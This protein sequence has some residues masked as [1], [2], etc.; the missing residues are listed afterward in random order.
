MRSWMGG[1]GASAHCMSSLP[2]PASPLLLP[3]LRTSTTMS[4][5]GSS[6]TASASLVTST[7][8][9]TAKSRT[10]DTSRHKSCGRRASVKVGTAEP[11]P[12]RPQYRGSAKS[13]C[14][15]REPRSLT[16]CLDAKV[17]ALRSVQVSVALKQLYDATA[18]DARTTHRDVPRA[19]RPHSVCGPC[20]PRS[21]E[22]GRPRRWQSAFHL[23]NLV[24]HKQAS[25]LLE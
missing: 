2:I 18:N 13:C 19:K 4:M 23:I 8:S 17:D 24:S 1:A 10:L 11:H 3:S 20:S 6:S 9:G 16:H 14:A 25:L 7:P 5:V 21:C 22:R 12:R 15:Q